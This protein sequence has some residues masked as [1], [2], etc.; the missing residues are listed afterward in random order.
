MAFFSWNKIKSSVHDFFFGK[1]IKELTHDEAK[2]MLKTMLENKVDISGFWGARKL[3]AGGIL[4]FEYDAKA[5]DKIIFDKYPLVLVLKVSRNHML[6]VNFHWINLDKRLKLIEHII[7]INTHSGKIN[8][9]LKFDYA[10][11]KP[12]LKRNGYK[13]CLRCYI[14]T[15][16]SRKATVLEP[17]YLLDVARLNLSKFIYP[18]KIR[19]N[20]VRF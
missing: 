18:T 2:N 13:L 10:K 17:K 6:G 14:K 7:N 3:H 12:F 15:H 11:L 4:F 1:K 8:F 9:P 5:K 16:M 19:F 20:R